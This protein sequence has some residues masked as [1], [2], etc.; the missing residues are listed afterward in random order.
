MKI[1][2][3]FITCLI[4]LTCTADNTIVQLAVDGTS[5]SDVPVKAKTDSLKD[6]INKGCLQVIGNLIGPIKLEKNLSVITAKILSQTGKFV[7]FYKA[8]DAVQKD[9]ATVTSV[10]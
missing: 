8:S 5:S 3:V 2:I 7:Q 1:L 6:A 10:N 9:G 4:S